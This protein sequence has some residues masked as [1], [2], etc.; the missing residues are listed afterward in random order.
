MNSAAPSVTTQTRLIATGIRHELHDQV[1]SINSSV[2][3]SRSV[4]EGM[5]A[6]TDSRTDD[7]TDGEHELPARGVSSRMRAVCVA[8]AHLDTQAPRISIGGISDRY[9]GALSKSACISHARQDYLA[10]THSR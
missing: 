7:L 6:Q 4:I 5:T 1:R 3:H 8:S 2:V 10:R 9:K